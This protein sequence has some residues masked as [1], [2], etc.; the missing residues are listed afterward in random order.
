[1]MSQR[2]QPSRREFLKKS[3]STIAAGA[4]VV[5][6]LGVAR[7]AHA[8]GSDVIRV[9]LVGSGGRG[10]GA[11]SQLMNADENV[12]L[13]AV[14]DAF[15]DRAA[16]AT[17]RLMKS[18]PPPS[19]HHLPLNHCLKSIPHLLKSLPNCRRLIPII[20]HPQL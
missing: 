7:G 17:D 16:G 1:M 19:W 14:A 15:E 13:V 10:T 4:A 18:S 3:T 2:P 12:K 20:L 6:T 8:A 9:A 5:G 11:A